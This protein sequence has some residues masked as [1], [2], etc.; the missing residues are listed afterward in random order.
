VQRNQKQLGGNIIMK[1][2]IKYTLI[3]VGVIA[4]IGIGGCVASLAFVGNAVNT[5]VTDA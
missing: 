4:I 3:S 5:A 1:K 2:G